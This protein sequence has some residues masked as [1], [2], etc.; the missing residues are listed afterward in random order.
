MFAVLLAKKRL[1]IHRWG[2]KVWQR[3]KLLIQSGFFILTNSFMVGWFKGTIY[4]GKLKFM[5]VPGMNCYSC[6]G[7]WGA[8]PIGAMQAIFDEFDAKKSWFD[9][10]SGTYVQAPLYWIAFYVIGIL[11]IIGALCGRLVCGLLCPFGWVQD[12]IYKIPVKKLKLPREPRLIEKTKNPR[13]TRFLLGLDKYARLLKY[14]FLIV[15]AVFLPLMVKANP[16][17]CKY[18]CPSGMLLGGIPLMSMNAGLAAAAGKLT[19]QKIL[20]LAFI[21]ILSLF[22]YRPFCRYIC[23]LGAIYSFFNKFSLYKYGIDDSKCNRCKGC[24]ACANSCPMGVDPVKDPNSPECIRC[25]TCNAKCPQKAIHAGFRTK[26]PEGS[27][28]RTRK[29]K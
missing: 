20:I 9:P 3:T 2:N 13:A 10:V 27:A 12:L 1:R 7:A 28:I 14:A 16:W 22:I 21:V 26:T 17:F 15:M 29:S 24:S 23:P 8:C 18:I 25:G 4:Q 19:L 6:P 5:C 11:M